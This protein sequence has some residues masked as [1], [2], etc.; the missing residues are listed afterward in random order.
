MRVQQRTSVRHTR[1]RAREGARIKLTEHARHDTPQSTDGRAD[2]ELGCLHAFSA[3]GYQVVPCC[4][5]CAG[6]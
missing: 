3:H 1:A 6:A 4:K 2:A 5:Q